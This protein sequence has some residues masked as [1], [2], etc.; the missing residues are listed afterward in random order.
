MSFIS[1]FYSKLDR[2]K[3]KLGSM[4][5]SKKYKY[6]DSPSINLFEQLYEDI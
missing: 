2:V 3:E 5:N 6:V 4:S 1:K